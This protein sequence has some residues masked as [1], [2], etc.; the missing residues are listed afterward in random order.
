MGEPPFGKNRVVVRS[1]S[2]GGTDFWGDP[3]LF[4]AGNGDEKNYSTRP[5]DVDRA[6]RAVSGKGTKAV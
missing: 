4:P 5:A 3:E 2:F 6:G 1:D